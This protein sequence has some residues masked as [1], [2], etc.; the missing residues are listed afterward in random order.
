MSVAEVESLEQDGAVAG[1]LSLTYG[2]RALWFLDRLAPG[3]PAYVIAGAARVVGRVEPAALRRAALALSA[4]HPALRTTFHEGAAGPVQRVGEAPRVDFVEVDGRQVGEAGLPALLAGAAFAPFDLERGPLWRMVLVRRSGGGWALALA[5]HHIVSD[6]WSLG[7]ILRDLGALYG[8]E[9]SLQP[10]QPLQIPPAIDAAELVRREAESLAGPR[11][12]ALLDFWRGALAGVPLVLELPADRPRP[13]A[14]GFRGASREVR[15]DPATA[16]AVKRLARRQ[17][18]TLYMGLLAAF[19]VLLHRYTGQERLVVGCPTTRRSDAALAGLVAY[20]VNP[21]P[22]PAD[23]SGDPTVAELLSRA[24]AAA[25]ASF[26]HQDVPLPLLAERLEPER[27][28]GRS[29]LFQAMLILQKGRR[30]SEAGLAALA[31]GEGG[32]R[33]ELGGA[34]GLQLESLP[35]AEPGVQFDLQVGLAETA[36]GLV[37]RWLYDRD[38]FEA[39]TMERM[40]GHFRN[41]LAALAEGG[42]AGLARRISGLPLLGAGERAQLLTEWAGEAPPYP[43]EATIHAL[44]AEQAERTPHAVALTAGV[45]GGASLTYGELQARAARL[46]GVLAAL[47]VGPETVVALALPRSPALVVAMLAV[48]AAGGAYLPL[49]PSFPEERVRFLLEEGRVPVLLAA[50][51]MEVRLRAS[52]L[53]TVLLAA[54]GRLLPGQGL[55]ASRPA[56]GEVGAENLAYVMFTSGSTGQPK[57]VAVIHRGVV[58]LVRGMDYARFGPVEVF[59]QLAPASFDAST[60]EVWGALLHGG[61]LVLMPPETPTLAE[62]GAALS[63]HGV[64]TL[65]L[66]AGLFHQMV[67]EELAALRPVR[68]LLAG[69]DALSPAHVARAAAALPGTRLINGYGPTEGTT[70]TCCGPVGGEA[71]E[72]PMGAVAI[73]RPIANTRVAVLDRADRPVPVGVAGELAVGGDGL[74]RGYLNR[75]D[76]TAE[77]FRPDP[78][79]GGGERL[80]RTGDRV[81]WRPDGR[82]DFLGRLDRQV[83]IR[84]FRIELGEI[85]AA[86]AACPGVREAAVLARGAG[87]ARQLIGYVAGEGLAPEALAT[88]LRRSLPGYMIPAALAVLPALPLNTNGKLDRKAL[89]AIGLKPSPAAPERGPRSELGALEAIIA[90]VWEELLGSERVGLD[91]DFFALGG[92]SLLATQVASRLRRELGVELP[93]RTLFAAPTVAA[94]A[95]EV[96]AA[97]RAAAGE[98]SLLPIPPIPPTSRGPRPDGLVEVPASFAQ[99][100]MWFLD[101]LGPGSAAYN[102]AGAVRLSGALSVAALTASFAGIVARH[103]TLRT[104]FRAGAQGPVQ[105]GPEGPVQIIAPGAPP[106]LPLA[107]LSGLPLARREGE[108]HRLVA[109]EAARPFDLARG[110]LLRVGLLRLAPAGNE[111]L[112]LLTLHHAVADG[113]SLGVLVREL[114]AFYEAALAGRPA[115]LPA[116]PVQY[117]DFA[118][119]QRRWLIGEELARQLAWWRERLA[120]AP[121]LLELPT[122][123]PRP[124]VQRQRGGAVPVVLPG[125]LV[126]RLSALGRESQATLFMVLLAGFAALLGRLS[127]SVDL[128]VGSPV[129]NRR[130]V[131]VEG[132]IGFFVNTLALR[133]DLSGDPGFGALLAR[134]REVTLGAY[135]HQDLPFER[136]VEELAPQRSLG[137]SPVFQVALALQNAPLPP[138]ALPGLA[139]EP[140]P[141][142]A[143]TAKFD[144]TLTLEPDGSG[145]RGTLEY[146][147]DLFDRTTAVRLAGAFARLL[148]GAAADPETRLGG[149]PLLA[150]GERAALLSEWND[151][152]ANHPARP[153]VHELFA[154][155]ARRRPQAL[156]V[157]TPE[158]RLTYGELAVRAGLLARRL[159]RSGV[160][161]E[162]RVAILAGFTVERVA[163]IVAVLLAGGA[164]VP[165]DPDSPPERLAFM[166]EDSGAAVLLVERRLAGRLPATTA[167]VL[168][169]DHLDGD[170]PAEPVPPPCPVDP[171]NLAYVVYTSGST[172]TPKGVAVPHA[173]LSNLTAWHRA[174]YAVTPEDRATQVASPAF[175]AAVWELWPYLTA[176]ASVH[177]PTAETRLSP[178]ALVAWWE[179]EGITLPYLPTPLAEGVLGE[180][181]PAR[182]TAGPDLRVRGLIC[183]GDRLHSAPA[184]GVPFPLLNHYGPSEVSVVTTV[185]SVHPGKPGVPTIGRPIDNLRAVVLD[186]WGALAPRGVTGE[187]AIGGVGLARGYLDR[188]ERTAL[189]FV[190]DP[191]SGAPGARLYRTGDLV[192]HL[193]DGDLDFLGRAD[194][195]VKI[196]GFRIELGEIEAA[197]R[198][199]PEVREAVVL[200][201]EDRP[202]DKRLVAYVALA[203]PADPAGA[204]IDALRAA[205]AE[206]LPS[207]M[208][209]GAFVFLA[210]LPLSGN[211]KVDRRALALLPPPA[212]PALEGAVAP[213]TPL[214]AELAGIW[215]D[216]LGRERVGV[217]DDFFALGGHSLLAARL[218]SRAR[219][220]FGVELPLRAIF[221]APTV[222]ALAAHLESALA[223]HLESALAAHLESMVVARLGE[224]PALAAPPLVALAPIS[225]QG[226][227]PLSFAQERLWFLAQLA[228][229]SAAYNIAAALA[230]FGALDAALLGA[231]LSAVV[232]RH[233]ALRTVFRVAEDGEPVQWIEEPRPVALPRVDLSGLLAGARGPEV[234]RLV[235]AEARRPFDL[236]RGPLLRATLLLEG[237]DEHVLLFTLH[238]IVGDGWSIQV[239]TR[240]LGALYAAFRQG[241]PSPLPDLPVQYA[242]FAVWQRRWLTGAVLAGEIA[243]WRERLA[244]APPL[245]TLPT[246][247]PRPP[248]QSFRGGSVP[249]ALS[250]ELAAAVKAL[251][252]REGTTLFMTFLAAYMTLLARYSGQ[253]DVAVGTPVAGRT[254]RE[255]EELI[256][257]FLNTLV[258]RGDLGGD[259][260]FRAL[261]ERVRQSVLEAYAHQALPFEMVVEALQPERSL[262]YEPLFQVVLNLH[263]PRETMALGDLTWRALELHQETVQFDLILTVAERP[264]GIAG[265]LEYRSDLFDRSTASRLLGHL[266]TLLGGAVAAPGRALSD[267]PLLA[268]GERQQLLAEWGERR[269]SVGETAGPC[270][271][272][273]FRAQALERPLAPA[274]VMGVESLTYGELDRAAD[275]LAGRL[276]ARGV[277]PDVVVGVC[278]ERSLPLL[279]AILGV[280][281]AG[282]AYLPL[283]PAYPAERLAFLLADA[284]A[285]V[286][287][288]ERRLAAPLPENAA[289]LVYLD[290]AEELAQND[291]APASEVRP[292]NLAYVIY[293]SGS[294][295]RPRGVQV[296]HGN[297]GRLLTETE[298]WF[299]FGPADVWTLF[300]SFAFDFSVWEIWGALAYGGTLVVVPYWVSRSP[301]SFYQLLAQEGVTVLNQTPSAFRQLMRAEEEAG[302]SPESAAL[303]LR[304]VIFGGEALEIQS[305]R[306]WLA[307]HGAARPRLVNMYGITETTVHVT[308]RPL[309][310]ADVFG[311]GGSVIGR[312]IPDL[313]LLVLDRGFMPQPIG[314][315][316]ELSISGAGLARGYLGLPALTAQKFVPEAWGTEPGARLY[317]SGDL[318]R[319]RVDGD[320]EYLGRIDDQVKV[321]GFRIELGEIEAALASEPGVREVAVIVRE[322]H[323]RGPGMKDAPG[324]RRLVAYVVG[325]APTAALR[326]ALLRKLPEPLVPS[327]IVALPALPLTVNGKVDRRALPAPEEVRAA[328]ASH[329]ASTEREE[330]RALRS[331]VEEVLAGIWE[332]VLRLPRVGREENFFELGGH[333]LLAT[334]VASRVRQALG[335]ELPLR[336]LFER[337]TVAGLAAAV[338]EARAA[339]RPLSSAPI[340]P[341]ARAGDLPLS[342]AQERLWLLDQLAPGSFAYNLP[343]ALRLSGDLDLAALAASLTEI[344]HRHEALRT[345]FSTAG[346]RPVQVVLA[347]APFPVPVV[348]LTGLAAARREAAIAELAERD[349]RRP[350][351]LARGP[352]FRAALVRLQ[353]EESA[354]L[355]NMHHIISDG[356]SMGIFLRELAALYAA[357]R[358]G[359]PSPLPELPIQCAD[360]AAW[361]RAELAGAALETEIAWWRER[362]AGAP[363][364]LELPTDR[365]R[366]PVQRFCGAHHLFTLPAPLAAAV[367]SFSRR[368]GATLFMTSLAAFQALLARWTGQRDLLV[369]S[370]VAGRNRR[371]IEGL[372]G[373]FV[374]SLVLR[375]DLSDQPGFATLVERARATALGA[376]DHQ[377]VPFEKLVEILKPERQLAQNPFFQVL[378]ALQNAPLGALALPGLELS[379][380]P[381]E[382]G[383]AK[384][385][386]TLGLREVG[387]RLAGSVEYDADLFDATTAARLAGWFATLLAA[388]VAEPGIEPGIEPGTETERDFAALPL[389][390]PAERQQVEIE[391]NDPRV[392]YPEEGLLPERIAAAA[393]RRPEAVALCTLAERVSYGEL[394]RRA[395]RIGRHLRALGVSAESRVGIAVERSPAMVAALLGIWEAGGAYLP[396]DPLL[397]A[398]RLGFM[399]ADAGVRVV[400]GDRSSAAA[401]SAGAAGAAGA[402]L[403]AI[404]DLLARAPLPVPAPLPLLP[405]QAAYVIYTSGSTGT[406]K[407]VTV[408]QGAL[409]NR[410]RFVEA[411]EVAPDDWFLHKTTILFDASIGEIF[412]PLLAGATL[413]LAAPGEERDPARLIE[414][415]ELFSVTWASF[416]ASM[417]LPLLTQGSFARCVS[418]R[419][420]LT[421]GEVVSPELASLFHAQSPAD[422][423]NRYGPTETTISVFSQRCERGAAGRLLRQLPLGWPIART[424]AY[425]VDAACALLPR[426]VPGELCLG[427]PSLTRGYHSR[428]E[429]TAEKFV[430]DPFGAVVPG[431]GERLYKTGDLV[432]QR[433]DGRL[434]FLGRIDSQVKIRGFRVELGEIEA[435]LREHPAVAAA[436]VVDRPDPATGGKRLAAYV[437]GRAGEAISARELAE[438]LGRKLPA[439]M[440]PSAWAVLPALPLLPTGKVDRRALPEPDLPGLAQGPREAPQGPVE[441]LLA[442]IWSDLLGVRQVGRED[443]FFELGGHSLL[444]TRVV[445]R[446]REVLGVEVPLRRLFEAPTLAG[447]AA[448]VAEAGR[449]D[450]PAAP[451]IRPLPGPRRL[452]PL[453]FAQ[454]RLWFLDQLQ[455]GTG[456][457]NIPGAIRFRGALDPAVLQA[458]LGW[459]VRRHESLRTT[460]ART[461]GGPVQAIGPAFLPALPEIDLRG[462][463]GAAGQRELVRLAGEEAG[464]PFDLATGPLL[465][466]ARVRLTPANTMDDAVLF[467]LHHI[468]GDGWSMEVLVRELA[469]AYGALA[470]GRAPELPPLPVQYADFAVWQRERLSG[471]ALAR[472]ITWWR[473][474][475]AGAPTVLEL[476][477][478]RPRPPRP[479]FRAGQVAFAPPPGWAAAL[480]RLARRQGAT[481]FMVL[482]AGFQAFLARATGEADLLVGSAVA[483]RTRRTVEGLIGFFVNTLVLRGEPASLLRFSDLVLRAREM[484]LGAYAHQDLPFERLV[485]ELQ[486]ARDLARSPLIQVTLVLQNAP[487]ARLALPGLTLE[488]LPLDRAMA[489]FDLQLFFR[490]AA[491][492]A[493]GLAG[494][495]VYA[496]DLYDRTTAQRWAAQ[497][498]TLLAAAIADPERPLADLPLLDTA[499]RHQ[500]LVEWNDTAVEDREPPPLVL[501]AFAAQAGRTPERV[502]VAMGAESV[503]YAEL[504]RRAAALARR[505]RRAGVEA[506]SPVGVCLPRS[507]DLVAALLAVW[508]AGGAYLPLDPAYPRER[509]AFLLAD[510]GAKVAVTLGRLAAQLP[511]D[512]VELVRLDDCATFASEEAGEGGEVSHDG[513]LFLDPRRLA[514]VIYTSGSTGR[515]KGVLVEHGNLAGLLAAVR[516]EFGW[517]D[518]EVMPCLAPASFDIFLFE[519]LAPLLGGGT[520]L[521]VPLAP[522]LDVE[523]LVALLPRL[524]RLHA[525]PALMRQIAERAAAMG[526]SCPGLRTVFVGG[527]AVPAEL[528]ADLSRAFP[529][530]ELRVLYGPTEG[531]ILGSSWRVPPGE[532]SARSLLGRPLPGVTLVPGDPAGHPVPI[533]VAGEIWLGG[534]GVARGYLGRPELSAAA[535]PA[536]ALPISA[537]ERFYR[538]G[539]R[540]RRL[541]DGT[542]E[543][544]GRG[545]QQV[546]IR[547]FRIEL[548]EIEAAL[549]RHPAVRAAVVL[550]R[551]DLPGDRR[552]VAY[553]VG[554]AS[555]PVLRAFLAERL[556]EHMFPAAYVFLDALPLSANGKVDRRALPAPERQAAGESVAPR[557][558]WEE[559]LAGIFAEVL[560][561][562]EV[563][564]TDDFFA[565]GGHS[566]LATRVI[567]RLRQALGVELPVRALFDAPTVALLAVEVERARTPEG[568]AVTGA[569]I[570]P[571]LVR[572]ER[573]GPLPL[574][575]GQERLWFLEQL[576]PGGTAYLMPLAVRFRGRLAPA[577]LSASLGFLVE[578]HEALRT[579][580]TRTAEGRPAQVVAPARPVALPRL[581]LRK[582]PP[583]AREAGLR[584]LARQEAVQPL[585]LTAAPLLR[586]L[587]V[588]LGEAESVALFTLHH[589]ASD[590]WS[591]GIFVRELAAAYGALLTGE[592]GERPDLPPLPIQYADF[593]LWQREWLAGEVL[594]GEIAWWRERLSGAP[595]LL[596]LPTDRPRPAVQRYR[597]GQVPFSLPADLSAAL[598]RLGRRQGATP[599]MLLLASLAALLGR[600]SGQEDVVVGSPIAN[601]THRETEGLIGLFVN[602]LALRTD[603]AGDPPFAELLGRVRE[604]TL[605]AYAHQDLPFEKL[606]E[607]LQPERSLAH[608]PIFQ[609]LFA[610]QNVPQERWEL[611]GLAL[612]PLAAP[613][614]TTKFDLTLAL[615]AGVTGLAGIFEYDRDLF[616]AA[617]VARLSGHFARLLAGLVEEPGVRL[618]DLPLLSPAERQQ[619]LEWSFGE[620]LATADLALHEL[621]FAQAAR[622]PAAVALVSHGERLSYG[623][624]AARVERLAGAL[625]ARGVGPEARVGVCLQRTAALPLALLA[626]LAAGGVYVPLDPDYPRERLRWMLEDSGARLLLT[627]EELAERLPEVSCETI[628][629]NAIDMEWAPAGAPLPPA[630]APPAPENLAYLIYTSGSTGLPKGVAIAHRSAVALARWARE[631]FSPAELSGVLFATSISFDLSVFEIFVPLAWGGRVIVADNALALPS[632]AAAGEVSLVNTVPSAMA[633]L[634]RQRALPAAVRTVNLA[635]EPLPRALVDDLYALG[636]IERV[637]NLYGP[638]E[639]TT[640]STASL[641]ER[642]EARPPRIGRPLAGTR[643]H[644][645][646]RAGRPVPAGV[647]GELY[648]RGAGLARGYLDRPELTAERFLPDPF[649][650]AGERLYRTGDLVRLLP[651]GELD[652]LG[653]I[654]HQVKVRGFRIE[655]GEIEAAL[656]RHPGV[657]A[658]IVLAREDR[659]GDRRLVAYIVG[660]GAPSAESLATSLAERLPAY[661]IPATFVVLPALPLSPNGKVDRKALPAPEWRGEAAFVAPSTAVEEVLAGFWQDLLGVERVGLTDHFFRLGGH[662]LLATE[663]ISRVRGAFRVELPLRRLFETPTLAALAAAVVEGEAKPG[664]SEKIARA[665]LRLRTMSGEERTIARR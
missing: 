588:E 175:D 102:V 280:L 629:L 416:T 624:L 509:L 155:W 546:K 214:E 371:E 351:D 183:G 481:P 110:P 410:M 64:T 289:A 558:P 29:P 414:L 165:L 36:R 390:T 281:K 542:L 521:L 656:V 617:T 307:R 501:V 244:G 393:A 59:L 213:R 163:G 157:A 198:G 123:R 528:L 225:R 75:P 609:L 121:A 211:G 10:L 118:L 437:V 291:P 425:I 378:F 262:S 273:R 450:E 294:T 176:G 208:V 364:L 399:L 365:P 212:E 554:D 369:G 499:E 74:A 591:M 286:I 547:G 2:Q 565:L 535:F 172:G 487:A 434:E 556:P 293:T 445:S 658:A 510:A 215:A 465:R 354:L 235:A 631:V 192:R 14:Q 328:Q 541:A 511:A 138:L 162:V 53:S 396:L 468:V 491:P 11:G 6:F 255:L 185:A 427:G 240:E 530:A 223:A 318:V 578:R 432:R 366:P 375:A 164:Y 644:V 227:P 461:E 553:V 95:R 150:S 608:A 117:A 299:G 418:L 292:E 99:E 188:P 340:V 482:L 109:A 310:E 9:P 272:E 56:R 370:P 83:K 652:F 100:R 619:L 78:L 136:L 372:I 245:L 613:V 13:A 28:P 314:V 125:E 161:P 394:V 203:D 193:A 284:A 403:L 440:V 219:E 663:L 549:E 638:S 516:E 419:T 486:P 268:P 320:L 474:R 647:A 55:P 604:V 226:D 237:A 7:V 305:L 160:G 466:A 567:A 152:A 415:I 659:P 477:A 308:Y 636:T 345:R 220:A 209:P 313:G 41:L 594:T 417:L 469:A 181:M 566:L 58:R 472:Q 557:T 337:P 207:Y 91:D 569:G 326:Q 339:S 122:D 374:N 392:D 16:D 90:G 359:R 5:V 538:T 430:P 140:L 129:A 349:A 587:L 407:G 37:G 551:E 543:F 43:R 607:A 460:F 660:D 218:V 484:A 576:T 142:A 112:L 471:E 385:D 534:R 4:R 297:V 194:H 167:A 180:G 71:G 637:W 356:W 412:S 8:R 496:T 47:G 62:L 146:D 611:P 300:H 76:W 336:L 639:D 238:H 493:G 606:V 473:E 92:H 643:A 141:A 634:V 361:Q 397:P 648:L 177:V 290:E 645:L 632:L 456:L 132:L 249:Y 124:A 602:T 186:A 527:D 259:P 70:F 153:L 48:L 343:A 523:A 561:L 171:E 191:W 640:Y 559:L 436:A 422:L 229:E 503:T 572:R 30:A 279:V 621:F 179:R 3:N 196:R 579:T 444:A 57:G 581:D 60:L 85:E 159:R 352:L 202:G 80:Y 17:G 201:R 424:R 88:R 514:Y 322:D 601:R 590:G 120:G 258:L 325:T 63:R 446:V 439:H 234:R 156:A 341:V 506:E 205:L 642:G 287:V 96:E 476:P 79:G 582:L 596:E 151:T 12:E 492:S 388:A 435:A 470:A 494:T 524:T 357:A 266:T 276:R 381:V 405:E 592:P 54:D 382:S 187:L 362:L 329:A 536:A 423:Y 625:R 627:Q 89:A 19:E 533:G 610:L 348:D 583:A 252:R 495:L 254:H 597:G 269:I 115:A 560:G 248:V 454:E 490:E 197:L 458:A 398:E 330:D 651:T 285:P 199:R 119:W 239:L 623:E 626:V 380:L 589:I 515:P 27:D 616:D 497:L 653:R 500:L 135:V 438:H 298:P 106:A 650:G 158:A 529:A 649:S 442:G 333:S 319:R 508:K 355:V 615:R 113:W 574:S 462:L 46:A 127:G 274:V 257:C 216:V 133:A 548:P 478:D 531:T 93:L 50:P 233:E 84:G 65:W 517:E 389:L 256:G 585:D 453:S 400:L 498:A 545:D 488:L 246:D 312:A 520:V 145:L 81:R 368:S 448:A 457:Y 507:A 411:A 347:P 387:E 429:L 263:M 657:Q 431:A 86:L 346:G 502:A 620:P 111:Y 539:D 568:I 134:V 35:L 577:A 603:L 630:G 206:R 428:P 338:A 404:E 335:V 174:R 168:D 68:Q 288:T 540:A 42:E 571:P 526:I 25:L 662:S 24:R 570:A 107:D 200:A 449:T 391:W 204:A 331:P 512:G 169:L 265:Q 426:G 376:Y 433:P 409:G 260:T 505:L 317:R 23:L 128:V 230:G 264:D 173:G 108:A 618:S 189:S 401:V 149:L 32:V 384:F 586:A 598:E 580:F 519:L 126:L 178:R 321:R 584:R 148:G 306:P 40:A 195:Q 479:S 464:R 39:A 525:V 94:L 38:L 18:A 379:L 447:F 131:E 377:D 301:E 101:Q 283:D 344:V 441:E 277:G 303:A 1:D 622:T 253:R 304:L 77:R 116:L 271:H 224:A 358:A 267:L 275:L 593:A 646:D 544:L 324:D 26:A 49:D 353:A 467:T 73:G 532:A 459:L 595:A 451:E 72:E 315:P 295:G 421:G 33:L 655:L 236:A 552:L 334:Q 210:A 251:S 270:L 386:L 563:S 327:A 147:R 654:D 395:G 443:S 143:G 217:E 282:G 231:T 518:G 489:P 332:E 480:D 665:L 144:L 21:V 316:G 103:E 114:A 296:T 575:F 228:P 170:D 383:I 98:P 367:R 241:R 522:A 190:P 455:P 22:I 562:A 550:A 555:A 139:L 342:F 452:F 137:H 413:V 599:Y 504:D 564:V 166:L 222:A 34:G 105:R 628:L 97:R 408:S 247:R 360:H 612:E 485:E 104:T 614:E 475:L 184:P 323:E 154:G 513:T 573:H 66:T 221:E 45:A 463:P 67:D 661:M 483:N 311:G 232:R 302:E 242:D 664:Q 641:Q 350:F 15:L 82:L 373:F 537:G 633:E 402:A 69:G 605:A 182:A 51:E 406:P 363:T 278:L 130:R 635:G 261:L 309:S 420:V 600:W 61:R 31:V 243:Y 52:S 250:G 20:L 44:F 87:A